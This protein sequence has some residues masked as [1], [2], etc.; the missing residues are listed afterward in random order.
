MSLHELFG[1]DEA[2]STPHSKHTTRDTRAK[3][4][5]PREYGVEQQAI[6]RQLDLTIRPVPYAISHP[7]TARKRSGRPSIIT[8][9]EL[10]TISEWVTHSKRARRQTRY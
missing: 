6:A 4:Q 3:V 1:V 7:A 8:A 10:Q 2:G 9:E 5:T